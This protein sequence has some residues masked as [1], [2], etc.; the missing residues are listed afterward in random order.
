[1]TAPANRL[2]PVAMESMIVRM[3]STNQLVP[4]I[5]AIPAKEPNF[6]ARLTINASIT[7][8]DAT[9]N[10]IAMTGATNLRCVNWPIALMQSLYAKGKPD[11][12]VLL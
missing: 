9:V 12:S 3:E 4:I 7:C 10:P 5:Q 8:V 6:N 1:M 11:A 2:Q